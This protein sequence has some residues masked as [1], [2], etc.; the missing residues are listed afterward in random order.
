MIKFFRK[1]LFILI[2]FTIAGCA[3][4]YENGKWSTDIEIYPERDLDYKN[5]YYYYFGKIYSG[6][7]YT[8]YD[9][10]EIRQKSKYENGKKDGVW[11]WY[12]EDALLIKTETWKEGVLIK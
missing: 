2:S 8:K 4:L 10:G 11:S 9:N 3:I 5:G 7:N 1:T 12:S 6:N